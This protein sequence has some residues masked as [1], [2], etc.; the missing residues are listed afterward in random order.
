M[1]ILMQSTVCVNSITNNATVLMGLRSQLSGLS[2]FQ[3]RVM[4]AM[5]WSVFSR[6]VSTLDPL[7]I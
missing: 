3:T 7:W 6:T 1:I 4:S 5:L 2:I